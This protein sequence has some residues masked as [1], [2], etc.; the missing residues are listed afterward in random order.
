M[1]IGIVIIRTQQTNATKQAT[2]IAAIIAAA[3]ALETEWEE[4]RELVSIYIH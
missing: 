1:Q 2:T 4:E 3:R